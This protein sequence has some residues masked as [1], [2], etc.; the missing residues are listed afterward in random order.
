MTLKLI[1]ELAAQARSRSDGSTGEAE[2][3]AE[4]TQQIEEGAVN[5][6][7]G[8]RERVRGSASG[9]VRQGKPSRREPRHARTCRRKS[10]RETPPAAEAVS[11]LPQ[12][13]DQGRR[14]KADNNIRTRRAEDRHIQPSPKERQTPA[15]PQEREMPEPGA[16]VKQSAATEPSMP[17]PEKRTRQT[18]IK[19]QN[20]QRALIREKPNPPRERMPTLFHERTPESVPTEATPPSNPQERMKQRAVADFREKRIEQQRE[21]AAPSETPTATLSLPPA[22]IPEKD[23]PETDTQFVHP[24]MRKRPDPPMQNKTPSNRGYRLPVARGDKLMPEAKSANP[25]IRE[26]PRRAAAPKEKPVGGAFRPR[27]KDAALT[28]THPETQTGATPPRTIKTPSAAARSKPAKAPTGTK[29]SGRSFIVERGRKQAQREAQRHILH[30]SKKAAQTA[31]VAGKKL[32]AATIKAAE[33]LI[34][35]LAGLLGGGT[36]IAILCVLGLIAAII[37]SPFGILF[38]NAPSRGAVPLN[39]AVAQIHME[40]NSMLDALQEGDYDGIDI[41]G[42]PPD[43]R[44]VVAVFA[45]KTA[46]AR[47]GVDVAALTPDRVN[48]LRAVFW[49]MCV[50]TSEVETVDYPDSDPDDDVDDSYTETYLHITITAKTAEDMRRE[51]AF[52]TKQNDALDKLLIELPMMDELLEDLAVSEEQARALVQSL[53]ADLAPERRAV[54]EAACQ[55]VG[56]VTYFWGGKSLVIG[57]DDRWGT[58]QKVWAEGHRTTGTYQAYGLDCS[59]FVDWAFYNASD[60]AYYPGHG[61]GTY[62]Q[63]SQRTP[64]SWTEAQPGDLVFTA[65]IGHVGIV[66]GRDEAGNLLIIHCYSDIGITGIGE[67]SIVGRPDYFSEYHEAHNAR[68]SGIVG[69]FNFIFIQERCIINS[70][71]FS[72][73]NMINASSKWKKQKH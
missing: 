59:G 71:E 2:P 56:K 14:Q 17:T 4:A 46:D 20:T 11:P 37:V 61:G 9:A 54:V 23:I 39:T 5:L 29:A 58:L 26:R 40:L 16:P 25:A 66:G 57:W 49:D 21:F 50:V 24:P 51:Y 6:A 13:R 69:T 41:D 33:G 52:T 43:W 62:M 32:T 53:P 64:V 18:A 7:G 63:R 48:R 47:D 65:D 22:P 36:L 27:T 3:E 67:F 30:Q 31:A 35:A 68:V 15:V 8:I 73:S 12:S 60:G 45:A 10:T 19:E 72:D 70:Q 42:Q 34:S 28:A 44:E 55:L 1:K 38:S